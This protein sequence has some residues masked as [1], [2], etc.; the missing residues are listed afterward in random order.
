MRCLHAS[1]CEQ[2][3][4]T[5][6]PA[7]LVRLIPISKSGYLTT[8]LL[9][10]MRKQPR[11]RVIHII[12]VP[13][14][15]PVVRVVFWWR[16]A[17]EIKPASTVPNL[18]WPLTAVVLLSLHRHTSVIKVFPDSSIDFRWVALSDRWW[19]SLLIFFRAVFTIVFASITA[20]FLLLLLHLLSYDFLLLPI[21]LRP[22]TAR[23]FTR[24]SMIICLY[25]LGCLFR[26]FLRLGNRRFFVRTWRWIFVWCGF[27]YLSM[28]LLILWLLS[29]VYGL[30]WV[31][32]RTPC[33]VEY[34]DR[35]SLRRLWRSNL[36]LF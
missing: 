19:L 31:L 34:V 21:D 1:E 25:L 28:F 23:G 6:P 9:L 5:F 29:D 2:S 8:P 7:G 12:E 35:L 20:T 10:A 16:R 17:A 3:A 11:V 24:K 33:F 27:G 14:A 13:G 22:T 32:I 4:K 36:Q 15:H 18:N 26:L 30:S